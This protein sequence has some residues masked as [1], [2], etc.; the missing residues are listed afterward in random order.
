MRTFFVLVFGFCVVAQ[1]QI[2]AA[3]PERAVIVNVLTR[4]GLPVSGFRADQFVAR[5]HGKSIPVIGA[6]RFHLSPRILLL[7]DTSGSMRSPEMRNSVRLAVKSLLEFL[8]ISSAVGVITFSTHPEVLIPLTDNRAAVL[9]KLRAL[10]Q[11]E[12]KWRDRTDIVRA[13][14]FTIDQFGEPRRGDSIVLVSDSVHSAPTAYRRE[15]QRKLWVTGVRLFGNLVRRFD[16]RPTLEVMDPTLVRD[17]AVDS[18]GVA[19]WATEGRRPVQTNEPLART[20]AANIAA[21]ISSGYLV[22]LRFDESLSR[23]TR[24]KISLAGVNPKVSKESRLEYPSELAPC[25]SPSTIA[26]P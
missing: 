23:W 12:S 18:G 8:P 2:G 16:R 26:S 5:A 1:A 17:V 20:A 10:L 11:A 4:Q 3:C 15:L 13:A 6:T 14:T 25:S 22:S 24:W 21:R 9:E 19:V 7:I